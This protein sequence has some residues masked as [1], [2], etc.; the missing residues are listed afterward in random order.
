[1]RDI[2]ILKGHEKDNITALA[3][4]PIHP[5]PSSAQEATDQYT[6]TSSTSPTP[7]QASPTT[8]APYDSPDP[9]TTPAQVIY[10]AHK[11][12]HAHQYAVWSL[13]WHPLGHILASGSNDRTTAFWTRARPGDVDVN[14]DRWHI[15]EA[16][17]E[18]KGTWDRRGARRNRQEE[19]EQEM[20]DEIDGLVDQKMPSQSALPSLVCLAYSYRSLERRITVR[21]Q[22]SLA[23]A[24]LPP[25]HRCLGTVSLLLFPASILATLQTLQNWQRC[26]AKLDY[27]RRRQSMLARCHKFQACYLQVFHHLPDFLLDFRLHRQGWALPQV[28]RSR[29][30]VWEV[31]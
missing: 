17:A 14:D 6:T 12:Q 24:Q 15:G 4:H 9:S 5:N 10:P 21:N 30:R 23:W 2:C 11:I 19:E 26:W 7:H 29:F 1:M 16:A 28:C 25:L 27:L 20:E 18:A 31:G 8:I 3:F 13:D 22:Y